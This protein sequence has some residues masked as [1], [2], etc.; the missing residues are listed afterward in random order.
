MGMSCKKFNGMFAFSLYDNNKKVF[1]VRD[2]YGIKPIYYH[3]NKDKTF[4]YASEI[5]SIL[6][7]KDYTSN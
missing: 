2:R 3:F 4:V 1:L 5:K 7:Y 6:E